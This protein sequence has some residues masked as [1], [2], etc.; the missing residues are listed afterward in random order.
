MST[1]TREATPGRCPMVAAFRSAGLTGRLAAL[2]LPLTLAHLGRRL[3]APRTGRDGPLATS[4]TGL[5]HRSRF[6][7]ATLDGDGWSS[8][9]GCRVTSYSS[10]RSLRVQGMSATLPGIYSVRAVGD[11]WLMV[12]PDGH[13][14]PGGRTFERRE[15][16]AAD[17]APTPARRP[18]EPKWK[19]RRCVPRVPAA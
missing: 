17:M 14:V 2:V 7:T 19:L 1:S 3:G 11:R 6:V 12:A 13:A 4:P 18:R 16:R 9:A 8:R 15:L 10:G 5:S